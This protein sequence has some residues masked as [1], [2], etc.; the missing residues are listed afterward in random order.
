MRILRTLSGAIFFLFI[1][2]SGCDV[3]EKKVFPNAKKMVVAREAHGFK[4]D[5]SYAHLSNFDS[6]SVRDYLQ[7]EAVY[8]DEQVKPLQNL[9]NVLSQELNSNLPQTLSSKRF[10]QGEFDDFIDHIR[11]FCKGLLDDVRK[12][13]LAPGDM[14]ESLNQSFHVSSDMT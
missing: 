4:W 7:Q 13:D 2:V 12:L 14:A 11:I 6:P 9:I 3:S 8:F 1:F 10:R 5:D